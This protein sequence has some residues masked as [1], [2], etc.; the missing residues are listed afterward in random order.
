MANL[1]WIPV[2]DNLAFD[3]VEITK[4]HPIITA[5]GDILKLFQYHDPSKNHTIICGESARNTFGDTYYQRWDCEKV[6][7]YTE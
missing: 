5:T 7:P 1:K 4:S 3:A 6:Y 2:S